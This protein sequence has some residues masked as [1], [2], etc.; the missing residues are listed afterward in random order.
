VRQAEVAARALADPAG[1]DRAFY[2]GKLA[3]ARFFC[4]QVL[5]E[6]AGRRR[7]IESTDLSLMDL[8]DAAF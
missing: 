7:V 1:R 2:E 8:A 4:A 5:P 3:S 6:L